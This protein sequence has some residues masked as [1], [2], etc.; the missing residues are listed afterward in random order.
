MEWINTAYGLILLIGAFIS[1]CGTAAGAFV[2]FKKWLK[3]RKE[4]THK[5]NSE[6]LKAVADKAMESAEH[7]QSGDKKEMVMN[8]VKDSAKAAGLNFDEFIDEVS[9]FIDQSIKWYN[10][11]K[12]KD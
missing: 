7:S 4:K 1:L 5:E 2:A 10:N 3:E 8:V 11:M 9:L 6:L 12:Q